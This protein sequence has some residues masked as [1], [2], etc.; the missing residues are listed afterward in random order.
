MSLTPGARLGPYEIT[1]SLGAG[2]MGEVYRARDPRLGRD[3]AIKV[4]PAAFASDAERM[5]RFEREARLLASCQHPNIAAIY[6]LEEEAGRRFIVMECVEGATLAERVGARGLPIAE[7]LDVCRQIAAALEAAHEGGV[8]HRD[9]KP[10]N[11]K[12]TPAGEVKVLDFGLAKGGATI[13]ASDPNLSASPTMT[14][15]ATGMGVI[16][17]TAAYMSPEQ[18]RG[19]AVDRRTDI[20]SFG[21]VLFE[22]LTGRQCFAGETLSDTIAKILQGEPEWNVL[23]AKTPARV[24]NLLSRCLERDAKKRLRDIGD[25]RIELEETVAGT[26]S[27]SRAGGAAGEIAP[28]AGAGA[29]RWIAGAALAGLG[30]GATLAALLGWGGREASFTREQV[31]RYPVDLPPE[32]GMAITA[33]TAFASWD[34]S[35]DGRYVVARVEPRNEDPARYQ[36]PRLFVRRLADYEWHA[37]AGSELAVGMPAFTEDSR[38]IGFA[39]LVSREGNDLRVMRATLDD[40]NPAATLCDLPSGAGTWRVLPDGRILILNSD[41]RRFA[42]L[43]PGSSAAVNWKRAEIGALRGILDLQPTAIDAHLGGSRIF[44]GT[45][46]YGDDGWHRGTAV[47]DVATGKVTPVLKDGQWPVLLPGGRILF[48]RGEAL[49]AGK[50]DRDRLEVRGQPVSLFQGVRARG[51]W[52]PGAFRLTAG[53]DLVYAPG[54][55]VGERRQVVVFDAQGHMSP[56]TTD[57]RAYSGNPSATPNGRRVACVA[58]NARGIDEVWLIDAADRSAQRVVSF[59]DADVDGAKISPDGKWLAYRRNGVGGQ[60]G[61][62]VCATSGEGEPRSVFFCSVAADSIIEVQSWISGR[63]QMLTIMGQFPATHLVVIE[64]GPSANPGAKPRVLLPTYPVQSAR[65]SPDGRW[66]AFESNRS[67]HG[68]IYACSL[69]PDGATGLPVAIVR[70]GNAPFWSGDGA[71]IFY[72]DSTSLKFVR[73]STSGEISASAPTTMFDVGLM[74]RRFD[75]AMTLPDGRTLAVMRAKEDPEATRIEVIQNWLGSVRSTLP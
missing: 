50:F 20:W 37:V 30:L 12:I 57:V 58:T 47:F 68:Q 70:S 19:K 48:S 26:S 65:C 53:G 1:G 24:R 6:G 43:Q 14:Y 52:F 44:V 39:A 13:S 15:A 71:R 40:V 3:V 32:L 33:F 54:G 35:P 72:G 64:A 27:T 17:G 66:M 42:L 34:V 38:A 49:L 23:P 74:N 56:I 59:P 46:T 9:L 22:C 4:L 16:L 55:L 41:G 2:G 45:T 73:V 69:A 21:C 62:Y 31:V 60:N 7:A 51:A 10:G 29:G 75:G 5:A 67:G 63:D 25:A 11:V 36:G 8:I 28:R 18:A 61:L